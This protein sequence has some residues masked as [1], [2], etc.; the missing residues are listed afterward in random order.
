MFVALAVPSIRD[1]AALIAAAVGFSVTL[2]ARDAPM[3][4]G[5]LIGAGGRHRLRL[6]AK[7]R[8][9]TAPVG[10]RPRRRFGGAR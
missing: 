6:L 8:A 5:L 9:K 4:S 10:G 3:N 1:R 2:I 7:S